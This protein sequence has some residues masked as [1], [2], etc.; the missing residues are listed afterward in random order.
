MSVFRRVR[1]GTVSLRRDLEVRLTE[2]RGRSTSP[3]SN[4]ASDDEGTH[5]ASV[6]FSPGSN[7]EG[8]AFFQQRLAY[9]GK[10]YAYVR[11]GDVLEY[12]RQQR[13]AAST[14]LA[15]DTSFVRRTAS[16]HV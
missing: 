3:S 13:H 2:R 9:L 16:R 4:V 6:E 12:A 14:T 10:I 8:R 11:G 1:T 15:P 7:E 5:L